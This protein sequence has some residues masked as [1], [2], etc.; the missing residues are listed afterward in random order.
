[1]TTLEKLVKYSKQVILLDK[2][3]AN[4]Q[5]MAE[6]LIEGDEY[7]LKFSLEKLVKTN[8]VSAQKAPMM[9]VMDIDGLP[10]SFADMIYG[11]RG[12]NKVESAAPTNFTIDKATTLLACQVIATSFQKKKAEIEKKMKDLAKKELV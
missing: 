10:P 11:K 2:Q 4:L 3:I 6:E 8:E 9:F 5:K 1:M 7:I 12:Q